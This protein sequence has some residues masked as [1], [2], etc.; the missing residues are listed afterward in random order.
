M[1]EDSDSDY[2]DVGENIVN[3]ENI[4]ERRVG[5]Q[6]NSNGKRVRGTDI[7]WIELS[8]FSSV[9]EY[10]ESS[11]KKDLVDNFTLRRA[12]E[13]DYADTEHFTCKFSRKVGCLACP[14]QYKISFL[15]HCDDVVV[16]TAGGAT[17]HLHEADK[18]YVPQASKTFRWS[19]EQTEMV[20]QGVK[21]EAKPKVIMRNLREANLFEEGNEPTPLQLNNKIQHCRNVIQHSSQIFTTHELRQK[22][23]EMM[24]EPESEV[25]GY[26]AHLLVEDEDETKDP[27]FVVIWTTKKLL[28]RCNNKF[29]QDD[30]TYRLIWQGYPF[31]VSG[32]STS[33]GKFFPIFATLCSHEDHLAW[34]EIFKFVRDVA[35]KD[36]DYR[37]GDGAPE[38]TKAGVEI[39]GDPDT[40]D[41]GK[42]VR[43]MCWPHVYR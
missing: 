11:I 12:R 37:M 23:A 19:R 35:G 1:S 10:E 21:N 15:S 6:I 4:E 42:H 41:G 17:E 8:R 7:S 34:G 3:E 13:P 38:I 28:K 32:T 2:L 16:E 31:F 33:T 18:D 22:V 24:E 36:P 9:A 43:L 30:A 20:F 27:R 39:F 25:E 29:H 5:G 40:T 26:V 14:L